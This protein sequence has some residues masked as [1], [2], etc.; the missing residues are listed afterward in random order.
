[1]TICHCKAVVVWG[2]WNFWPATNNMRQKKASRCGVLERI[3][4]AAKVNCFTRFY[5]TVN[6]SSPADASVP[7][8]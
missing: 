4:I 6:P 7:S 1:M 2:V 5:E 8:G 3:A